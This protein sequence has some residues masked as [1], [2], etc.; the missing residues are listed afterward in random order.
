MFQP[1][2][3]LAHYVQGIWSASV[4]A[5]PG[6]NMTKWLQ[7]DAC[8]GIMFILAGSVEFDGI[9]Y[10]AQALLLPISKQAHTIMLSSGTQVAGVRFQPGISVDILRTQF[11]QSV[12][13]QDN[14]QQRWLQR[15]ANRLQYTPHHQARITAL[16]K[17][18]NN[19][20]DICQCIPASVLRCL[21]VIQN[22]N[23]NQLSKSGMP[24]SQ[25]QIER[26]FQ[27]WVGIS[28]KQCQRILRVKKTIEH[29]KHK[30]NSNLV[31]LALDYGFSDQSHMTREFAQI[32][33]I[34]PKRYCKQ[35]ASK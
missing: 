17:W 33:K 21:Q 7:A 3:S 22:A 31:T 29:L 35:I 9:P 28:P 20:V 26:Q 16:Y 4:P 14:K 30:P 8:S 5:T 2:G 15:M 18:L 1:K 27:K 6:K 32:A 10:S 11:E 13:Q 23:N 19:T 24:L 25:R 12:A 34:T